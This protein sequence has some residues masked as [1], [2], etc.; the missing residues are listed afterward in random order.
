MRLQ[1]IFDLYQYHPLSD[2]FSVFHYVN[3]PSNKKSYMKKTGAP[4]G[5]T[6][7]NKTNALLDVINRAELQQLMYPKP[8][9]KCKYANVLI[10]PA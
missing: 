8:R 2:C 10:K 1:R 3:L 7:S 5:G 6:R 9:S 4:A